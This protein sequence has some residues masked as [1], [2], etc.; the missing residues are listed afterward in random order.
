MEESIFATIKKLLGFVTG[1]TSFDVDIVT[2]INSVLMSLN[3]LGIG[4]VDGFS[5]TGP[6]ETWTDFLGEAT[7][8]DAVKSYIHQKVRLMIDPP[9]NAFVL[10]SIS[11]IITEFEW[12][13]NVQAAAGLLTN[14]I[15]VPDE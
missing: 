6:D 9:A 13:L 8:L 14:P 11:K 7:N 15:E 2:N 12:R 3:M 10:D 1:D 5:I 4:P